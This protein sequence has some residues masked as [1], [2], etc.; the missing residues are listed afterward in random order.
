LI[1]QS[2]QEVKCDD[3]SRTLEGLFLSLLDSKSYS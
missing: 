2:D 3:H 1:N